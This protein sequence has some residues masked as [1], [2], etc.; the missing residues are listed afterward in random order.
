MKSKLQVSLVTNT[1]PKKTHFHCWKCLLFWDYLDPT[2]LQ[3]GPSSCQDSHCQHSASKQE[4]PS[5]KQGI[6]CPTQVSWEMRPVLSSAPVLTSALLASTLWPLFIT[7]RQTRWTIQ[8]NGLLLCCSDSQE[9]LPWRTKVWQG[10]GLPAGSKTISQLNR[11][12]STLRL[13]ARQAEQ[14]LPLQQ[15]KKKRG[16]VQ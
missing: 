10:A 6:I 14:I 13:W 4:Q 2:T 3:F 7:T 15:K 5:P 12:F 9:P 1:E 16:K 11:T 8:D